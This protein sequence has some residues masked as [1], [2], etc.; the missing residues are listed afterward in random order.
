MTRETTGIDK[1]ASAICGVKVMSTS[2]ELIISLFG[3]N[4]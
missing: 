1:P 2:C 4:N 3:Q